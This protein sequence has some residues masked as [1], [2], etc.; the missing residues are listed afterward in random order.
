MAAVASIAWLQ[1]GVIG[2]VNRIDSSSVWSWGMI[3]TFTLHWGKG[4]LEQ[5]GGVAQPGFELI[6]LIIYPHQQNTCNVSLQ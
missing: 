2:V 5:L 3:F 1:K 6:S 4:K